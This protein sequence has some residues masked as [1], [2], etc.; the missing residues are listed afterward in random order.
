[1][2]NLIIILVALFP[3]LVWGQIDRSIRP[4]A[5]PAPT[6]N[7]KNSEVFKTSNGITV[8]LSE[9]HS[10]PKV[11]F[12]LVMDSDP[13]LE[14][15]KA[16]LANIAGEMIKSGTSN[17]DKDKLDNE[18]DYIGASLSADQ[19]S[20]FLS[21]L[22]KY[23]DKGLEL[24]TDILFNANFPQSEF[25]RIVKQYESG[26]KAQ[27]SN[28]GQMANSAKSKANFDNSHPYSE[29]MTEESLK[30][31]SL[32]DVNSY[33]KTVF[34]PKGSYLVVVGDIN[35][36]Q[37]KELVEKY[38]VSW[39]GPAAYVNNTLKAKPA[40]GG[41]V[42]FVN[43][44]GAV[45]SVVSITYPIDV[46][47]GSKDEIGMSVLNNLL[48]G[49]GFGSRLMQNLREDKA[50]TY[51]CY[52][53]FNIDE[54]GST[55]SAG[56]NFRNDVTDSAITQILYEIGRMSKEAATDEELELIKSS[57]AGSFA[58]SLERPQTIARFALKVTKYN[59][60]K[61]YYTNYLKNL[62]AVNKDDLL[63]LAKKYLSAENV[64]IIVVGN[65]SIINNLKPFDSNGKIEKLDAFG[66]K[67]VEIVAADIT[68]DKLIEKYI[69]SV[70]ESSS[71]KSAK[72]KLKKIKSYTKIS[73]LSAEQ[74]P[75]PLQM[76]DVWITPNKEGNKMEAQGM[77]FNKSYFDGTSGG[78]SSMQGGKV[79]LSDDEIAKK[80]KSK[81]LFPELN[82]S[83]SGMIYSLKG[84]E[85][86]DG[87]PMYKLEYSD[88]ESSNIDYFDKTTFLKMQTISTKKQGDEVVST[89]MTFSDYRDTEGIMMPYSVSLA[90]GPMILVGTVKEIKINEKVNLDSFK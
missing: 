10:I 44:P 31:I 65:E 64:N 78:S 86:I 54:N 51:G 13:I 70:T 20:I 46:I 66:A 9:N 81:G 67:V 56:G 90:I 15:E 16:G 41:Q 39:D 74:I 61:D 83:T 4:T 23:T 52:S 17:R 59:L 43:K 53:G 49:S 72:K 68:A 69:L 76:T 22:S 62:A 47:P 21:C 87:N 75:F 48:G 33:F 85:T 28:P 40:N 34:T 26:L 12:D 19:N 30:N 60:D 71:M 32:E 57:M 73:E 80:S 37:T 1:M 82:Y 24:M 2:K 50:Y 42:Y 79:K 55:F 84:I 14:K 38:F 77:T 35:L 45:Q 8:I 58:R 3:A 6:I 18:I 63:L 29:I 5:G 89:E 11:S 27:K 7:I 25:D 88:G 36:E